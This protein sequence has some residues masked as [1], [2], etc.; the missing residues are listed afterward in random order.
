MAA[1]A[2]YVGIPLLLGA[3]IGSV[4]LAAGAQTAA[5]LSQPPPTMDTGGMIGNTDPIRP[6]EKIIRALPGEAVLDKNTVRQIGGEQGVKSLKNHGLQQQQI[7]VLSP[8][9][10]LDRYAKQSMIYPQTAF[11]SLKNRKRKKY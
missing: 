4:I 7:V 5:V 3:A 8:F 9:K 1:Q 10:H 11:G 6:D 2:A